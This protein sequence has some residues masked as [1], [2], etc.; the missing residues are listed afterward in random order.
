[1]LLRLLL[2]LLLL[3]LPLLLTTATTIT[4]TTTVQDAVEYIALADA[5]KKL[6]EAVQRLIAGECASARISE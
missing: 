5:R 2:P 3:L 4:T 6:E 1:V